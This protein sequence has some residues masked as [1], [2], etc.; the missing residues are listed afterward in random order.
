M[1]I[2]RRSFLEAAPLASVLAAPRDPAR[3]I[4]DAHCHAGR[5]LKMQDPWNTRGDL[6]IT[7]RNMAEAGIDK[8]IIFPIENPGYEKANE[9]IAEICGRN[10]K[11]FLGFAR[12]DEAIES[13]RIARLLKR[14]VESLGLKGFKIIGNPPSRETMDMIAELGIPLLYHA[15]KTAVIRGLAEGYPKVPI[16]IAH[17]G[18]YNFSWNENVEA[19]K[20]AREF[21]NVYMDTSCCS[22]RQVFELMV[23]EAGSAKLIFG[24]DG[25]EFDSRVV[26]YRVKLLNLPPAEEEQVLGGTIRR[27]LPKGSI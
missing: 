25:P 15:Y 21:P 22:Y 5:G 17:M 23:K 26:L 13:G 24:S 11:Q 4:I 20:L 3:M 1:D 10:P 6:R 19:I 27:L 12:H 8:T 18:N 9:E 16:I 7:L 14:E 2:S